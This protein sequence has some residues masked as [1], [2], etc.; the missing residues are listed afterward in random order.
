MFMQ[1]LLGFKKP[2][3][4]PDCILEPDPRLVTV[5]GQVGALLSDRVEDG[6]EYH[7]IAKLI[8]P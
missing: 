6:K 1:H 7:N 8:T 4:K 2:I 3:I 5:Q